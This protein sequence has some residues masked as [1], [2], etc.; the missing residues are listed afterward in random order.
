VKVKL[1]IV[2]EL[3]DR[4]G[5]SIEDLVCRMKPKIT[6]EQV[7]KSY[8]KIMGLESAGMA[9]MMRGKCLRTGQTVGRFGGATVTVVEECG[10]V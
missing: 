3:L 9:L 10:L 1:I 7:K 2:T 5:A 4:N 6:F 8:C